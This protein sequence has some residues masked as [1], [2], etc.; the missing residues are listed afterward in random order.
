MG[1][2][3]Q[4]VLCILNVPNLDRL[5][6]ELWTRW[7]HKFPKS[8]TSRGRFRAHQRVYIVNRTTT[9]TP[10]CD[11]PGEPRHLSIDH[12][13]Q[14]CLQ[15]KYVLKPLIFHL[16]FLCQILDNPKFQD[17]VFFTFHLEPYSVFRNHSNKTGGPKHPKTVERSCPN[18]CATAWGKRQLSTSCQLPECFSWWQTPCRGSDSSYMA[19]GGLC[20]WG[21]AHSPRRTPSCCFGNTLPKRPPTRSLETQAVIQKQKLSFWKPH[22]TL[23]YEICFCKT[24]SFWIHHKRWEVGWPKR[25]PYYYVWCGKK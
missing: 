21:Y 11:D 5:T 4:L 20:D 14:L 2:C 12:Y 16:C 1:C 9:E 18:F 23:T 13:K 7:R 22:D 24:M 19:W 3:L 25:G 10:A 8:Q 6:W 15:R 17:H